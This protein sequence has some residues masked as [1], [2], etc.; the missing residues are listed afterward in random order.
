MSQINVKPIINWIRLLKGNDI[1]PKQPPV[2]HKYKLDI[3]GGTAY[4]NSQQQMD[5]WKSKY[6]KIY[7]NKY[8]LNTNIYE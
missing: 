3:I 5:E 4:F 8:S 6:N 7:K 1:V 2:T